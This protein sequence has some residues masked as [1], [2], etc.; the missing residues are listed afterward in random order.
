MRYNEYPSTVKVPF[1]NYYHELICE[2]V[3]LQLPKKIFLNNLQT[4]LKT[5]CTYKGLLQFTDNKRI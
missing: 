1:L 3:P 4:D 2:P 5:I